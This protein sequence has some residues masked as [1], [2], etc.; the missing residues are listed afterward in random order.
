MYCEGGCADACRGPEEGVGVPGAGAIGWY[1]L[2]SVGAGNR[3]CVL[4]KSN[5]VV[6]P[7]E[8]CP[9]SSARRP[10]GTQYLVGG[11]EKDRI[12]MYSAGSPETHSF[13]C[14]CLD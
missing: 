11:R 13:T 1:E 2:H 10:E 3:T 7:T 4:F 9:P 5:S 12:S 8:L 14:P 6:L